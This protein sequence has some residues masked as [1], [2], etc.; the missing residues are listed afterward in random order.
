MSACS[1]VVIRVK[2]GGVGLPPPDAYSMAQ[3]NAPEGR[4]WTV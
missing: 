1:L 4:W 3:K 2:S